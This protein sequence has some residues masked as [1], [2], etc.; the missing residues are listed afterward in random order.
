MTLIIGN[1]GPSWW[2]GGIGQPKRKIHTF[3][4]EMSKT[5]SE[6][7]DEKPQKSGWGQRAAAGAAVVGGAGLGMQTGAYATLK[8]DGTWRYLPSTPRFF[9]PRNLLNTYGLGIASDELADIYARGSRAAALAGEA[10]GADVLSEFT[11]KLRRLKW[12]L[13]ERAEPKREAMGDAALDNFD[14]RMRDRIPGWMSELDDLGTHPISKR[15][16]ARGALPLATYGAI[17]GLAGYGLYRGGKALLNRNQ[18]EG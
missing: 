9:D 5:A 1:L 17:G 7:T 13:P 10:E 16:F 14:R 3:V 11:R 8:R 18:S 15:N 4:G 6:A 12:A 2:E